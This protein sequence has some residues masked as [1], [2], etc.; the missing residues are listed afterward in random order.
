MASAI[1]SQISP[2]QAILT[3]ELHW[4]GY[5]YI[6]ESCQAP[7]LE[8]PR[9]LDIDQYLRKNY[10]SSL[11][12]KSAEAQIKEKVGC[13]LITHP[14]SIL[15]RDYTQQELNQLVGVAKK[16]KL[17]LIINEIYASP[18]H[19]GE[20]H[21]SITKV[22]GF[23]DISDHVVITGST[24]KTV[25]NTQFAP[26]FSYFWTAK[27]ELGEKIEAENQLYNQKPFEREDVLAVEAY[28]K[29]TSREYLVGNEARSEERRERLELLMQGI[30]DNIGE[31]AIDWYAGR[32]NKGY[33][34]T[35]KVDDALL[36]KAQ[37]KTPKELFEYVFKVAHVATG[38]VFPVARPGNKPGTL[39]MRL[40]YSADPEK[41]NL[42][43]ALV[44]HAIGEM[45][46]GVTY[47]Q[48]MERC[49]SSSN[50]GISLEQLLKRSIVINLG[51]FGGQREI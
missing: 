14:C 22:E 50:R 38:P 49:Q 37:I 33:I 12:L 51:G 26:K 2:G 6:A 46:K 15:G 25:H 17:P 18:D 11:S 39:G 47:E 30:C 35:L 31:N 8:M 44:E 3:P 34:S 9:P 27:R 7:L 42:A 10:V 29:H 40:N 36:K 23:D 20:N 21:P 32:P 48:M 13:I 43:F 1:S 5:E 19:T 41:L 45:Q 28:L 4:D 16:Y 24:S